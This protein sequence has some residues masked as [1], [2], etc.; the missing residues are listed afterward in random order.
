[1]SAQWVRFVASAS[2]ADRTSPHI[3]A[4]LSEKRGCAVAPFGFVW[5][6]FVADFI[7]GP[8]D[9]TA[10]PPAEV[11]FDHIIARAKCRRK[12]VGQGIERTDM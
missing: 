5:V 11:P 9:V 6:R 2:A 10:P 3:S 4:F 1:M 12:C 7:A 8:V